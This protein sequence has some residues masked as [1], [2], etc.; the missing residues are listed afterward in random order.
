MPERLQK[1]LANRGYGSRRQVEDWIRAGRITVDGV[2]ATLGVQVDGSE[3]IVVDGKPVRV[4]NAEL[5]HRTLMYHKPASEICTR[6]DPQGRRTVFQ[7]LPKVL[8][9]RWITVGRLDYQTTGLLLVTT[10]GELA[11]RLMHPSGE[12]AREYIV[13]VLGELSPQQQQQLHKRRV[14]TYL[15]IPPVGMF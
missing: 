12:F 6:N 15:P 10:D 9:K 4:R 13:R 11:N 14:P 3:Q 7:S 8:G 1:W 2:Q 5:K